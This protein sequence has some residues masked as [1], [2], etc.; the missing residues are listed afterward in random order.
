MLV[1]AM[2][3]EEIRN[4]LISDYE[5]ELKIKFKGI[6]VAYVSKWKRNGKKNFFETISH[7]TKTNNHWRITIRCKDGG[8]WMMPYLIFYDHVG[9]SAF[10]LAPETGTES[11]MWFNTHFFKRYRE[12]LKIDIEKPEDLVKHFFRHN[13]YMVPCYYPMPDGKEQ[14][15]CPLTEGLGLGLYNQELKTYVFKTY[16]DRS[17]LHEEQKQKMVDIWHKELDALLVKIQKGAKDIAR[18]RFSRNEL[19]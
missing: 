14:L 7:C 15:F 5:T 16:V 19:Y 6:E 2:T 12:R 10:Y 11:L 8:C 17:L 4:A 13:M 9:V 3:P 18:E 1:P